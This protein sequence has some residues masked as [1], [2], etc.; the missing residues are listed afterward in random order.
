[1]LAAFEIEWVLSAGDGDDFV[2]AAVGTGLRHDAADRS[3]SDY[4]RD[5]LEA[6]ARQGVAVEQ[7]H[8]E[9]ASGPARAVGR[10]RRRR[11]RPPTP[12]V[13]VR[14]TIRAVGQR[15]GL[16]TSFSPKVEVHG[17]GNGGHVHLSLWRDV[18]A[19]NLMAGG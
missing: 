3:V 8:P 16:R 12:S 2:P 15:H 10:G 17:V 5:L 9:Y 18:T 13:L 19:H 1:M 14:S 11:S 4:A 6:L 7:F